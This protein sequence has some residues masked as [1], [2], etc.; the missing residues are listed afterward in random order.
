MLIPRSN[1]LK[2]Q[3]TCYTLIDCVFSLD[4]NDMGSTH[5]GGCL[6]PGPQVEHG[7]DNNS[8]EIFDMSDLDPLYVGPVNLTS[9]CVLAVVG[10]GER[11]YFT[12]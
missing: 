5:E 3:C 8:F 10:I 1:R 4:N 11:P 6:D 7:Q 2:K 12:T 9:M